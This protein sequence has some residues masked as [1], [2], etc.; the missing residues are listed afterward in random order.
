MGFEKAAFNSSI[1][2]PGFIRRHSG[3]A[4]LVS[5]VLV[6]TVPDLLGYLRS[7]SDHQA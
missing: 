7:V 6:E 3:K 4:I 1:F 2:A 5:E